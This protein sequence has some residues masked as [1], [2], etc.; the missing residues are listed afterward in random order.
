ML[1]GFLASVIKSPHVRQVQFCTHKMRDL[2]EMSAKP[3]FRPEMPIWALH[4]D[5]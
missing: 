2:Y 1:A 5:S 3:I 4:G